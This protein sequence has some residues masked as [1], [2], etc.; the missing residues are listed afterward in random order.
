MLAYWLGKIGKGEAAAQLQVNEL[1][2]WQLSQQA[3]A[4]MAAGLLKQPRTRARPTPMRSPDED[5][6]ML[7]RRIAVLERDLTSA[8]R[9]VELLKELPAHRA[10]VPSPRATESEGTRPPASPRG[11]TGTRSRREARGLLERTPEPSREPSPGTDA[12]TG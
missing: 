6:T 2:V 9:L 1:R 5:P 12:A 4:G 7:K 8:T 11:R 3:L 10:S